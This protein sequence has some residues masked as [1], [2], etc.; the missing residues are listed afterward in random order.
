MIYG[1]KQLANSFRTVRKNTI[2]VAEDIPEQDYNPVPAAE[3][4]SAAKMLAHI[5]LATD[6][7]DEIQRKQR[8]TA[9]VGLNFLSVM[10]RFQAKPRTKATETSEKNPS[11]TPDFNNPLVFDYL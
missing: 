2:Q 4:R 3:C 7:W 5:A 10:E 1:G 9:M 11:L 8:L 6:I